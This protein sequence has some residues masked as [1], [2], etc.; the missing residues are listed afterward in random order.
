MGFVIVRHYGYGVVL[1]LLEIGE[2]V[3]FAARSV[4]NREIRVR[5]YYLEGDQHPERVEGEQDLLEHK[6][7]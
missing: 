5:D 6:T 2:E 7:K 4:H 3:G 1:Q